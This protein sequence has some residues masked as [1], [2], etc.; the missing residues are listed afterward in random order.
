[1][2][3]RM[4]LIALFLALGLFAFTPA[5]KA[6]ATPL[7]TTNPDRTVLILKVVDCP[8]ATVCVMDV[9]GETGIL[10]NQ[11][12]VW[13]GNYQAPSATRYACPTER[14]KGKRAAAFLEETLRIA[15]FVFLINAHKKKGSPYLTGT[16]IVDGVDITVAMFKMQLAVPKGIKVDWCEKLSRRIEI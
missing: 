1:M 3:K 10:G 14:W 15:E 13:I 7:T 6:P 5:P 12:A 8:E 2:R 9:V 16:L 4:R 11:V